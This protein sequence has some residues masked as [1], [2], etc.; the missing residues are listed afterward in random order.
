M[1]QGAFGAY[2]KTFSTSVDMENHVQKA[3]Q[4]PF[5]IVHPR[6]AM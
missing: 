4:A 3:L 5:L 6:A 1:N 2:H